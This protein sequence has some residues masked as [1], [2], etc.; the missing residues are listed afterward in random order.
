MIEG[1]ARDLAYEGVSISQ[2][3]LEEMHGLKTGA[4]ISAAV[5]SGAVMGGASTSEV[6]RLDVFAQ[7]IGLAFQVVDDILNVLGTP[8]RLGKAVG[9]DMAR[10]KN[11][12]P[13]LLGL[14][15][16]QQFA[17]DLVNGALQALTLF[18]NKADPLRA[19]ARYIVERNR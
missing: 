5:A 17:R 16:A 12:Y 6:E 18:D 1:Q 13:A 7:K 10:R 14:E 9:T 19:L 8:E 3:A 2:D 4:M 11:T 15:A